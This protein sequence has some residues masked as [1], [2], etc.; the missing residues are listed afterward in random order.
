[1]KKNSLEE[2]NATYL[3][4][5]L[6]NPTGIA[7]VMYRTFTDMMDAGFTEAQAM[8]LTKHTM[9]MTLGMGAVMNEPE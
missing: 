8:E 2:K 7:V 4:N 9:M 3:A 6:K 5:V 1:M